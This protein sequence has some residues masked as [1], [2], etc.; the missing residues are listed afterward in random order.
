MFERDFLGI[1]PFESD[2]YSLAAGRL[3]VPVKYVDLGGSFLRLSGFS[4]SIPLIGV[5]ATEDARPD[6]GLLVLLPP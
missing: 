1:W 5:N 3:N 6:V 2:V 4:S